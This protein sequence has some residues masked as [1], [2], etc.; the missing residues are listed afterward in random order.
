MQVTL[1]V[2]HS[3]T[4]SCRVWVSHLKGWKA[5]QQAIYSSAEGTVSLPRTSKHCWYRDGRSSSRY[6]TPG[7]TELHFRQTSIGEL[8]KIQAKSIRQPLKSLLNSMTE[9]N[10]TQ[11]ISRP[12]ISSITLALTHASGM[13]KETGVNIQTI[14]EE[15]G[16]EQDSIRM[17]ANAL[18]YWSRSKS[19]PVDRQEQGR[20]LIILD[21]MMEA[22][23]GTAFAF[24]DGNCLWWFLLFYV[25][26]F[27]IFVLLTP[28]GCFHIFS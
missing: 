17:S 18:Q 21:M 15:P 19:H 26:V 8:A 11:Y 23:E 12:V 27:K 22:S 6:S 14:E 4:P 13:E 1:L 28:C 25:L 20:E 2:H 16:Y 24:T 10:C 5:D 9:T 7:I 3:R